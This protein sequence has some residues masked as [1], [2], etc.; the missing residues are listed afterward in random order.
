MKP[1]EIPIPE[2]LAGNRMWRGMPVPYL[3]LIGADGEPD[4]RVI[5]EL[6]RGIVA[7]GQLC[8]L[9]GQKLGRAKFFVGGPNAAAASQYFEPPAHLECLIYAMQVCPFIL[10]KVEH[11]DPDKVSADHDGLA[12]TVDSRVLPARV[13]EWVIVKATG[14][15]LVKLGSYYFQPTGV[16]LTH[17]V[18]VPENMTAADWQTVEATLRAA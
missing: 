7:G 6:K 9:C 18:L 17:P 1:P 16:L 3:A 5:D 15:R 2:K 4:F 14:Y 13:P 12:L 10:G 11:A 8:Q